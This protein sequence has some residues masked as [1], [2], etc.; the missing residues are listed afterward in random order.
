VFVD[1]AII[2]V[3]AGNG[4]PG[5]VAFRRGKYEPKGGP[6]GGDGGLGG[7]VVLEA[8]DGCNTL[9][10]FRGRP[11]WAAED[12]QPG[13]AK[14]CTG[15]DG[16]DRV[17]RLPPGTQVFNN[18]TGELIVDLLPRQRF[19]VAR[20]G[21]GG[22][23][24]EHYKNA[25]NQAPTHAHPG[26]PGEAL[27]LRLDLK[28]IADVG[29]VG[30]PNAGKS[31]LL[32]ALTRA[33]PKI[34]DYPFTTLAPQLGVAELGPAEK[35]TADRQ[36]GQRRIVIADLP[37]LIEG[38]STGA[39]LG[40]D[41]LRHI[42]R[43]RVIVHLLD[44]APPDGSR[45]ADNYRLIRR[46]LAGYSTE[47]AERDEVIALNKLDLLP[48]AAAREDAVK[49][50]RKDLKLGREVEVLALS[51]AA[52][53]GTRELLEHLWVM[54]RRAAAPAWSGTLPS[55]TPSAAPADEA[56]A[57]AADLAPGARTPTPRKPAPKAAT[58]PAM[59]P[60]AK[61][62]QKAKAKAKAEAK[63][64]PKPK[65]ASKPR[66]AAKATAKPAAKKKATARAKTA[67]AR[68]AAPRSAGKLARRNAR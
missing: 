68:G 19:V 12:G 27:E 14:Q 22:F 40:H 66:K 13:A 23:G 39:G 4:G 48:D 41:F 53:M 59:K 67:P 16:R 60:R 36:A 9:L 5:A 51:G 29:L 43:T 54:L 45:P 17:I 11:D 56:P 57:A 50:L 26:F 38:A 25:A 20:G 21:H 34:A 47:L 52:R 30:L 2:N 24:N 61:A 64:K 42:E 55:A 1:R 15:A 6:N 63:A 37:G 8:D 49:S 35:G 33:N 62:K 44:A 58:K 46:E 3:R 65:P 10:D 32:K 28:L 18:Q 31:T 7:N